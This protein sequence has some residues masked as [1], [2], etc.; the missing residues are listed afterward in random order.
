MPNPPRGS[1]AA[2]CFGNFIIGTGALIVPGMLPP[3]AEGLSV[4]LP[5]AGQ[6]IT[7]F[8]AAVCI[9]APLLAGATSRYDRRALLAAM[10]ILFFVGHL[11]AALVSSFVPMLLVRVVT[12]V[13]AAVFT[14]QAAS[15]APLRVPPPERGRALPFGV[16]RAL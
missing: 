14:A 3:L 2:L 10:Q 15:A 1:L 5:V 9:G 11:A 4:S 6:L 13:G 7:A 16:V 8:A 12:S